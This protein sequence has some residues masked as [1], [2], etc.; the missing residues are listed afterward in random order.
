VESL[1]EFRRR[2]HAH[3]ELAH[4]EH[5][6]A[7]HVVE[8][9][10]ALGPDQILTEVGGTGVIATFESGVAG[11][12]ILFRSELDALPIDERNVAGHGSTHPGVSHKCGHDGHT[13]ILVGLAQRLAAVRPVSGKVHLLFQPAEETGT[14]AAAVLADPAFEQIR[15]DFGVA[16]HNMPGFPLHAIVVKPGSMCAAV[17]S[18][19]IR[20]LGR[21]AHAAEP[22]KGENPSLAIADLIRECDQLTDND[23]TSPTFGVITPVHVLIGSPA[24]GV[25]AGAGEVHLTI[26]SVDS[27]GLDALFE[28]I[29][30]KGRHFAQRDRLQFD[31][32]IVEDFRANINDPGITD[33]VH[34]AA[35]DCGFD[36]IVPDVGLPH[37]EDFGLF[38]EQFPCCMALL[39]AGIAHD[40]VH[41]PDY[42]FP[43]ELIATGVDLLDR[44]VR[45]VDRL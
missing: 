8:F 2:L 45:G 28:A 6:T 9:L 10:A 23:L 33:L 35:A 30:S 16:I 39:G 7:R 41:N 12:T 3:P 19:V 5:E 37:G 14:G 34:T 21:T 31:L 20:Y 1:I 15:P 11:P 42:D 29:V 43:D 22:D 36:V 27:T 26:R 32:E 40:P 4:S 25:S 18:L 38:G 44:I 13:T 17:R 24:Y